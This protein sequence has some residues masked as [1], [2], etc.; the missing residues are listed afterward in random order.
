MLDYL[1]RAGVYTT[2]L[3]NKFLGW[4]RWFRFHIL[5]ILYEFDQLF[6][7]SVVPSGISPISKSCLTGAE[8]MLQCLYFVKILRTGRIA[9]F[10]PF[11]R[12]ERIRKLHLRGVVCHMSFQVIDFC[13]VSSQFVHWSCWDCW[14][15]FRNLLLSTSLFTSLMTISRRFL[16][17]VFDHRCF[18]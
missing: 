17:L 13:K 3:W 10:L 7:Y 8:D 14:T 2:P 15:P 11:K 4:N 1:L 12:I 6:Q 9:F 16:P 18:S 5:V